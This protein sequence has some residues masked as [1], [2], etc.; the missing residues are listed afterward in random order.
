MGYRPDPLLAAL[1]SY[2]RPR[3]QY[4]ATIAWVTNF[5]TRFG[6]REEEIFHEYFLGARE[7]AQAL[8]FRLQEFWLREPTMTAARA[9]QILKARGIEGLV[10]APQPAPAETVRLEWEDF[11]AVAI[12]YSIAAPRLHMVAPNQYR[13]MSLALSELRK[14][15]Y[16][17]IGLV[18]LRSS[19]VRVDNNWTAGFLVGQQEIGVH[20]R[21]GTL[22]LERWNDRTFRDW[23]R[24]EKPDAIIS[25]CAEALP[26]LKRFG[27]RLPEDIGLALLT[28]VKPTREASGVSEQPLE[29][30]AAAID[31]VV[32]M[33]QRGER[34]VPASPR[35]LLVE[36]KWFDG[37]TVCAAPM[38]RVR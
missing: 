9:S 11:A 38:S 20:E 24:R 7:R 13:C 4:R 15:G 26:S 33:L 12:G 22:L 21:V 19:D 34:G 2:A 29:V 14:L 27:L 25:K 31:Y 28:R 17:R 1:S 5:A 36:G 10:I 35:R 16:Q 18:I 30:G 23:L 37:R 32:A 8:G 6:W 3:G